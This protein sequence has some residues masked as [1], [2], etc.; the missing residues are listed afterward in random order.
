VF[1]SELKRYWGWK[2][3]SL[4]Y[5]EFLWPDGKREAVV[6]VSVLG[7]VWGFWV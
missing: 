6:V 3:L 2:Y 4:A 1:T 7:F 5:G